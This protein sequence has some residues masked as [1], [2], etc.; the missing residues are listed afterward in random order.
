MI[1]QTQ[2]ADVPVQIWVM[3]I[4]N[5]S[6][7]PVSE[8][9]PVLS[10]EER[11]VFCRG[12]RRL[13][14]RKA[15]SRWFLRWVL[16]ATV[17]GSVAPEAWRFGRGRNGKPGLAQDPAV[18]ML[19]FNVSRANSVVAAAISRTHEVGV[20][21]E[22][23]PGGP[24][25]SLAMESVLAEKER[26]HLVAL[27]PPLRSRWLT[28]LWTAKEAYGKLLGFGLTRD[29][30][31]TQV[32]LREGE[33]A[34]IWAPGLK[35]ASLQYREVYVPEPHGLAVAVP[36]DRVLSLRVRL[37]SWETV[38]QASRAPHRTSV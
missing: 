12:P 16:S 5:E 8:L 34:R 30:R 32:E 10:Q 9:L 11:T 15:I 2:Y 31:R 35:P 17:Q 4:P 25:L 6:D 28:R 26:E 18:P 14:R 29:P 37:S 1:S 27:D 36:I 19:F 20:D 23:V 33:P 38:R 22:P 21:I 24:K 7:V 3:S 13:A